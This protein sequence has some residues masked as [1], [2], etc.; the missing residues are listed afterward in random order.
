MKRYRPSFT[1]CQIHA[2][3]D[4]NLH[5]Y[6]SRN[7]FWLLEIRANLYM[8]IDLAVLIAENSFNNLNMLSF[9]YN[10]WVYDFIFLPVPLCQHTNLSL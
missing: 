10:V 3:S 5:S 9:E 7:L 6:H 4:R 8:K 2:N 1:K